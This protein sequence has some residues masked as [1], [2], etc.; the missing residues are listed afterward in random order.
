MAGLVVLAGC[1]G[2]DS[3]VSVTGTVEMDGKPLPEA[4]V[5]FVTD[6][7]SSMSSATTGPDGKFYAKV[8]SGPNK[9]TVSKSDPA[10]VAA[11]P[12]SDEASLSPTDAELATLRTKPKPK[13]GVPD[14]FGDPKTS[15][16]KFDIKSGMEPLSISITSK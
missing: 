2:S 16:L 13:T 7:G 11:Q 9:V 1:G 8:T 12:L 5:G 14:R 4:T 10:A 6:S 3:R 15:G